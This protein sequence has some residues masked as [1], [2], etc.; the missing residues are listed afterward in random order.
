MTTIRPE[1]RGDA[2]AI[3]RVLEAAFPTPAE[4]RLVDLLRR[5][6]RLSASMVAEVDGRIVG[7]VAFSPVSTESEPAA[8]GAGLAPLAV[9]ESHRRQ[10]IAA[11]L[12]D[13]GLIAC[14]SLGFGWVVVLGDPSYYSRFGFRPAPAFGLSDEYEGGDAFQILELPPGAL[15]KNA[16]LVRYA[17]E[18]ASLG[19]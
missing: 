17:P 1:A 18:F 12:V 9:L 5:A 3:R 11:R 8:I 10:G 6:G 7:H 13:A 16:G 19:D 15:P 2:E 4:A 14:R